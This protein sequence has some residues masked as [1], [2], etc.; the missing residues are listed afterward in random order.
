[1]SVVVPAY[2][3]EAEIEAL[4]LDLERDVVGRYGDVEA[5]VVD[6]RST[7]ATPAILDRLAETRPWLRVHHAARNAGHG[8]SVVAGL[9]LSRGAWIFQ[10]DSD[11]QFVVAELAKLWERRADADLVLGVRVAR[12]DPFHRIVLSLAVRTVVSLLARQAPPR[13]ERPVPAR[14]AASSGR[15]SRR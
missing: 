6:D 11:R 13:L 3:E 12:R 2:N 9:E 8:P 15:S 10:L 14:S 7:D 1:M 4:V 5:I